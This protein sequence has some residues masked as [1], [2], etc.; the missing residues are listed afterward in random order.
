MKERIWKA[1]RNIRDFIS[2]TTGYC[3][4][5][6]E[7][8]SPAQ[9]QDRRRK[10]S[11]IIAIALFTTIFFIYGSR[12]RLYYSTLLNTNME[13]SHWLSFISGYW[14]AIIGAMFSGLVT[15]ITTTMIIRRSYRIDYHRERLDHMPFLSISFN[16]QYHVSFSN[17]NEC[18]IID[19]FF[20][21]QASVLNITNVGRGIAVNIKTAGFTDDH[22]EAEMPTLMVNEVKYL[23]GYISDDKKY[24]DEESFNYNFMI[25]YY[26]IFENEYEQFFRVE[27]IGKKMVFINSVPKLVR[28][29][30]R[31]RYV[32]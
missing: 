26:D 24:S 29:T 8:P 30:I 31:Y 6:L 32:Q 1:L 9:L 12:W 10:T 13:P 21:N 15:I 7:K 2:Y 17:N 28:K 5:E 27:T 25:K 18:Y 22:L 14:G 11:I 19:N 23:V 3:K 20:D 16:K 4:I